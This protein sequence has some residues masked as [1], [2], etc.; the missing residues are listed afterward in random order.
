MRDVAEWI[1][2]L[3]ASGH[4]V[5]PH[6]PEKGVRGA[7]RLIDDPSGLIHVLEDQRAAAILFVGNS[8]E[9]SPGAAPLASESGSPA[10]EG[11]TGMAHGLERLARPQSGWD[12]YE[13]WRTRV[14]GSSTVMP[15][16]ER[17][18][19]RERVRRALRARAGAIARAVQGRA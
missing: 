15:E 10:S 16:R 12:P 9:P 14:K 19:L 13:V 1:R 8:T 7:E 5:D 6:P 4:E 11:F 2:G 17:E 18:P 3:P